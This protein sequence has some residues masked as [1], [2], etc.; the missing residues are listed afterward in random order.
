MSSEMEVSVH[1]EIWDSVRE[2]TKLAQ[3]KGS[4]PLL[5]ALQISSN[6][7][8][9]GVALPSVELADVLVSYICWENNLPTLWKFLE[10][11]LILQ[12]VPP[13]FVLALLSTRVIPCRHSRPAAYRLYLELLKRHAFMLK[14]QIN[15]LNYQKVMKSIDD[16]LHLSQRFG[17]SVSEPG[18]LVV[19]FIFS[20]VWQLLD[21]TLDDEGLLELTLE[22]RSARA[23]K[24]QEMEIDYHDSYDEKR[25][26]F[27]E[28]LQNV[29]TVTAIELIGQF[30]QNK[31]T[32]RIIYLARRN[33]HTHWVDFI[34]RLRLLEANS[35]ALRNS[36]ALTPEALN[37]LTSDTR[38][39]L[40][41]ECKT[42]SLQKFHGVMAFGSLSTSAGLC[43]GASRSA[44]WLP[45]DLLLEDAMDGY[46]VNATSAIEIITGLIKTLQAINGTT[47]HDT[48]LGL[49][50]A[51]L[52]L[53][54]RERD[55][56]EGPVPRLDTRLCILLSITTL[57]IADLI[58][59]EEK[60]CA[61]AVFSNAFILLLKLWRFN[62][63]PLEH[64]VGGT[65][66]VG[67]QLTPEYLLL[68]RNS[69]LVYP[70]NANKNR[71][72][73]R[74]SAAA[75]SSSPQPVFVDSFPKLKAWYRQHQ[76]CIASTLSGL[77]HGTPVHQIVDGLLNMMFKKINRGSQ[78]LISISVSSSSSGSGNEDTSLRPKLPAWDILEAVPFVVDAALTA[79]AHGKLSPRELATG[80]KDLADFLPASLATIV[81]YFSAEVTRGVWKPVFMN[82]TDWPS[83]AANLSNVEEQIKKIL[84]T[85]GVDIPSPAAGGSSPSTL[86]LPLAAFVSLTI[87]YKIDRASERFLNLAGPALESLAAGCPWPCMPIVA[88]LWTQKA[89]HWSDF[90]VFS[91][92]RTVFLHNSDAMV[93]L[94]KSCFTATLGL[95]AMPISSSGG[96][97]ALLGHGFGSHF[98]GGI[99][100]VAPGIL[101]LRVYRSIRDIVFITEEVVSLL[102]HSVRE[103]VSSGIPRERLE[104]LRT[105]K[106]G[107]RYRQVS[108]AAA[109]TRVKLAAA[110]GASLVWL[111]GG[112]SLVQSLIKETLPSL[113]ISVHRSEQE[114]GSEGMVAML[115]GYALAYF[116]VLCGAFA[117]GV[118]S[119]SSAS[120]RRPKILGTHLEFLASAVDGKISL[121]CDWATWR[122]YVS[123]FVTLMVGCTPNWVLEVNGD[124]LKR[125]SNGLRQWDEEE[126]ALALLG[127]GGVGTMGAAAELIIENDM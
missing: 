36:K 75:S 20:I 15:G 82:G 14:Y 112:L 127:I 32:S 81:S 31:V 6:L 52:R 113:F 17:M 126:L 123:G 8:S 86:P 48:F 9:A 2:L 13:M 102:M 70:G 41:R 105:S 120:K 33:M 124:V 47:W 122:A 80:L 95:N 49:W 34:Q 60:I 46:L 66:T 61:H 96:V 84:A 57:V 44:L 104:K 10:K 101:Y 63:P 107:M 23:A 99:S 109:M 53:V 56:I 16:V 103:I 77:V 55:P 69:H 118:D 79:C 30:L 71:N 93:Q 125:L 39:V 92:S 97:G 110:L 59:E 106:I 45:L 24:S 37:Q 68:L 121:G 62:H 11:A 38:I 35:S 73:R 26:E 40:S 50:I 12:I 19:E 18:I 94:L 111:S 1:T 119:T 28:R 54:Q 87:T 88:S 42:T 85:T 22:K 108:L 117:W 67:S 72:R 43:Q 115:G 25:A 90:L 74:L 89:K 116:V 91:A 21:A 65:P 64:G 29:N 114:E 83:P 100:P 5:W 78:S 27:K 3:R 51:A 4:D 7:N 98:C 76:A 58:E